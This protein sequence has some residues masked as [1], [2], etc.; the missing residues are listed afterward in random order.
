M[1]KI[2]VTGVN[3]F[4]GKH[5]T[6]ELKSGGHEV[7][8]LGRE[9]PHPEIK[10]II[11]GYV[12]CDLTD[13][14]QVAQL[15]LD[16]I[17]AVIN[18]AGLAKISDSFGKDD[19]YK[20]INVE[21]LTQLGERLLSIGSKARVIAISTGAVYDSVQPMPF[22]ESSTTINEDSAYATSK[23]LMEKAALN[24]RERGLDC[25]IARP[26]NHI[27]PGQM[28]GFIVPDLYEKLLEAKSSG[29]IV[30]G[31]LKT[32]RDYT[33]VR[34]VVRAYA[35]LVIANPGKLSSSIYNVCSGLTK[36]GEDVLNELKKHMPGSE[37]IEIEVDPHFIRPNDPQELRGSSKLINNDT[38]WEPKIPFEQTIADFVEYQ[39]VAK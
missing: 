9:N 5:L 1:A 30:V 2:L 38:G 33:D 7:M 36:S 19:L 34:D 18:L 29:K 28:S 25:V 26:F 21:V 20:K 27:G 12:M 11:D 17:N 31:N 32:R 22:T 14:S 23:L 24:L 16:D 4:V 39:K 15:K 37:T 10:D 3:G 6:R 8:G 13:S 35:L